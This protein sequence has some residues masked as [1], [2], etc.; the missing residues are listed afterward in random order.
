MGGLVATALAVD[1][2][3][4]DVAGLILL[5]PALRITPVEAMAN[6]SEV[7]AV[8]PDRIVVPMGRSGF[9]ASS[10]D[11]AMKALIDAD[12]IHADVPGV[13]A[14]LLATT[15]ALGPSLRGRYDQIAVPLLAMHGTGDL[16]ADP[17]ATVELVEQA[18]APTR[19][20]TS[21]PTAT[22]PCFATSTAT[23]PSTRSSTGS[24]P[25]ACSRATCRQAGSSCRLPMRVST[26][27]RIS[28]RIGR[29]AST[30]R[31]AG[32]SSSQSS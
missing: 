12:P 25:A 7:A 28:S 16:M 8:E 1:D 23:P 5:G 15:S 32:S 29:T 14:Q 30:P 21:S 27:W 19:R 18:A 24:T 4:L 26:R 2:A 11:P 31:P 22:T 3:R 13:P 6:A 17:A 10:R 9:D 20:C